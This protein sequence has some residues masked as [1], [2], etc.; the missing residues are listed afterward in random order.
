MNKREWELL[1]KQVWG[2]SRI[3]PGRHGAIAVLTA[4]AGLL[5]GIAIGDILVANQNK[6]T[7]HDA[8]AVLLSEH[9]ISQSVPVI[10]R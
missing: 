1:D 7:S 8:M 2:V 5:T 4:V 3:P 9:P 10:T 6:P